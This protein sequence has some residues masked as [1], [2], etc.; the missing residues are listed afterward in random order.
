MRV[1]VRSRTGNVV[2]GVL[3]V[4]YL[5]SAI[6][7]LA[8]DLRQTWAAWTRIDYLVQAALVA[9]GLTG[10]F[11]FLNAARNLGLQLRGAAMHR[12]VATR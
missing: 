9:C 2:L 12:E 5:V 7:L 6:G 3:G 4:L 1:E 8:Y 11:F 10:L